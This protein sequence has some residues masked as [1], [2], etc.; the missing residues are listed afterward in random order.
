MPAIARAATP[1]LPLHI[2]SIRRPLQGCETRHGCARRRP[3]LEAGR[4]HGSCL[5]CQEEATSRVALGS[6]LALAVLAGTGGPAHAA[7]DSPE[8]IAAVAATRALADTRCDCATALTH[9]EY[10]RCV[11][12]V[13]N[14]EV[15]AGRLDR[16]CR[17]HV[18]KCAAKS[19]CGRPTSY[20]PCCRTDRYAVTRCRVHLAEKCRAGLAG[21]A[22][23]SV[24]ERSCCDACIGQSCASPSGAFLD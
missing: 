17:R 14:E 4:W 16:F 22:C 10:V 20:Y 5:T 8:D 2:S 9:G 23:Y 21:S 13:A 7:C 6:L 1:H 15:G 12:R 3:F 24:T 18:R 11:T 19:T